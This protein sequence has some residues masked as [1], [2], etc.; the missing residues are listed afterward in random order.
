MHKLLIQL[1]HVFLIGTILVLLWVR[2][3]GRPGVTITDD[4]G[5]AV[6]GLFTAWVLLQRLATNSVLADVIRTC[7]LAVTLVLMTVIGAADAVFVELKI[8]DS[9]LFALDGCGL[10]LL[11][12]L[13]VTDFDMPMQ[14]PPRTNE[15]REELLPTRI[16][17]DG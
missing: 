10:A 1:S 17:V 9:G 16:E 13:V 3:V 14:L 12:T 7:M 2:F 11:V 4:A 6:V 5:G 15:H 8:Q